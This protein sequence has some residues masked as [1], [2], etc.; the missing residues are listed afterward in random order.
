MSEGEADQVDWGVGTEPTDTLGHLPDA[1]PKVL[2][3]T[4]F[5]RERDKDLDSHKI[6]N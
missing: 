5:L 3:L 4:V 2:L 6:W 1:Q